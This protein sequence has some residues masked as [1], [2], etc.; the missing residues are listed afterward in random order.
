[1]LRWIESL[2]RSYAQPVGNLLYPQSG[3]NAVN[4]GFRLFLGYPMLLGFAFRRQILLD[5]NPGL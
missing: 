5:G 3:N 4:D 1:M 2:L